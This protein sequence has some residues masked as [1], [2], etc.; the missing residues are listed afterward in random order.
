MTWFTK[1]STTVINDN[2]SGSIIRRCGVG[3]AAVSN[4]ATDTRVVLI[5]VVLVA[6]YTSIMFSDKTMRRRAQ[7]FERAQ[8]HGGQRL[9][10]KTPANRNVGIKI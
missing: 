6:S 9:K 4:I 7:N 10:I 1:D 2:S 5:V 3:I 8:Y